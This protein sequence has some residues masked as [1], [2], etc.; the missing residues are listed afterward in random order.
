MGCS[1]GDFLVSKRES[2]WAPST[3]MASRM[4]S[5]GERNGW[6]PEHVVTK[7]GWCPGMGSWEKWLAKGSALGSGPQQQ[8]QA[9]V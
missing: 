1:G 2:R 4:A 8:Y 9:V 5:R 6:G 3:S 7:R